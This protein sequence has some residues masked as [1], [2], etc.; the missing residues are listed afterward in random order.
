MKLALIGATGLVGREMIK[1]MEEYKLSVTE[2]IPVASVRSAG[3]TVEFNQ[4]QFQIFD[5]DYALSRN[6]DVVLYSAG[7]EVSRK[8]AKKFSQNGSYV[9]DNS[10]AWRMCDSVPLVVPEVNI[11]AVTKNTRLIS[12]PNCS[13]IQLSVAVYPLHQRYKIK[14]LIISTYQ[15]VT[16]TGFMGVNQLM[17]ERAGEKSEMIYPHKID[18]NCF[19]H[20]GSF[21]DN[22]YTTEEM[23][24]INE[25]HKIFNDPAIE[26]EATV[27]RIPVIGGHSESVYIEFFDNIE[28]TTV[29]QILKNSPGVIVY[30]EVSENI[31]PMPITVHG[32]NETYVGRIR[33]GLFGKNTLWMWVV[34]DNLRKGAATNAVQIV[35][36]IHKKFLQTI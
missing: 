34:A 13:V 16:G 25:T 22:G 28:I 11:T 9:I 15:S 35:G 18:L 7:S 8:T 3:K 23:K 27:V 1:V 24:L 19:P 32:I 33:K 5:I 21:L 29:N 14:K 17:S 2:F 36:Y 26:I 12:N 31:Y 4:Q 6:P 20:G 10:S 30:D